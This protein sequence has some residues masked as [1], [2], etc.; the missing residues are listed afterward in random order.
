MISRSSNGVKFNNSGF[1]GKLILLALEQ[2]GNLPFFRFESQVVQIH[3]AL[4]TLLN[5]VMHDS[6]TSCEQALYLLASHFTTEDLYHNWS[7][8]V[9]MYAGPH[10][11][12]L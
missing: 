4:S 10:L 9:Q 1:S 3:S 11:M 5:P 7:Q 2:L 8:Q 12:F 6:T